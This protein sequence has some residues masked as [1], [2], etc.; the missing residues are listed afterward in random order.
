VTPS[1]VN[2]ILLSLKR[3]ASIQWSALVVLGVISVGLLVLNLK[4]AA[5]LSSL[6][7]HQPIHVIPG[8]AEGVYAA[9]LTRYNVANAVRYVLGLAVN[10]TPATAE[11]RFGELERYMSPDALTEFRAERDER[12]REIKSQQQSRSFVADEPDE[13]SVREGI[14]DYRARGRWE[15]RSGSLPMSSRR[16]EFHVRFRV[17]A[18]D[19]GNPYGIAVSALVIRSLE[20]LAPDG[21]TTPRGAP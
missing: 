20:G 8:A 10:V 6:A 13:L 11:S 14:Y 1:P 12:L 17:G 16:H 15:I 3:T 2:E 7:S 5:D 9:G 21:V 4:L 19:E 18:P